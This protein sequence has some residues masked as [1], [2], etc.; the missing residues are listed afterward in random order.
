LVYVCV[1]ER[2]CDVREVWEDLG[3][4][5]V[6]QVIDNVLPSCAKTRSLTVGL[7]IGLSVSV[8]INIILI[9]V[10]ICLFYESCFWYQRHTVA[11]TGDKQKN[12][13]F[14]HSL[15]YEN[16][17]TAL[18]PPTNTSSFE[19]TTEPNPVM[20]EQLSVATLKEMNAYEDIRK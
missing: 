9:M 16:Y 10:L 4:D 7:S 20:Y 13:N 11:T 5:C 19:L 15:H 17:P 14:T 1:R 18:P 3:I 8:M 2:M 12:D 6:L